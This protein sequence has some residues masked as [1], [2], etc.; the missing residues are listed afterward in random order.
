VSHFI[1]SQSP[2]Y[3]GNYRKFSAPYIKD[4]PVPMFE[5]ARELG[6]VTR[7]AELSEGLSGLTADLERS[8]LADETRRL[9]DRVNEA[10]HQL[11]RIVAAA[12]GLSPDDFDLPVLGWRP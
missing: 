6:L 8:T 2:A 12:Y 1:T 9:R 5:R 11:D 4:V 3:Q 10:S 7:I